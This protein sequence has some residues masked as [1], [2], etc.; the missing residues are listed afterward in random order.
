MTKAFGVGSGHVASPGSKKSERFEPVEIRAVS[1]YLLD[2]SQPFA[3]LD[4]QPGVTEELRPSVASKCSRFAA[5]WRAISTRISP[6]P[7]ARR[8]RTCR[9]SATS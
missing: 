3:Y 2:V 1:E 6:T 4:K 7:P 5:A 9:V 8:A